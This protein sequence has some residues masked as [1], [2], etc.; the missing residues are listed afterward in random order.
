MS[1]Y[2]DKYNLLVS[3]PDYPNTEENS[4]LW[5]VEE[6]FLLKLAD[7]PLDVS[8]SILRRSLTKMRLGPGLYA[9]N[10]LYAECE[11]QSKSKYMS[12]DQL[13]AIMAICKE[14]SWFDR[15]EIWK[16]IKNQY[17]TYNNVQDGTIR[18]ITLFDL[19]FYMYCA[20]SKFKQ[21]VIG[22]TALAC[23]FSC[24]S[25]P[26]KTSGKLLTFVRCQALKDHSWTMMLTGKVCDFLINR[27]YKNGW[28]DVFKIY[29]PYEDHPLNVLSQEAIK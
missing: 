8:E 1:K 24:L 25:K 29:F 18:W 19:P 15:K 9:Q 10:P 7:M 6:Y 12:R 27:K 21:L 20:D 17:F 4:Y 26:E 3:K 5:S 22:L 13:M 23:I 14:K 11:P 28:S 2:Y 16:E